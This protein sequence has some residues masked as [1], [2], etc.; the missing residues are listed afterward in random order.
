[1]RIQFKLV[2]LKYSNNVSRSLNMVT[3][4]TFA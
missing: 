4:K 3:D 2:L 1:M